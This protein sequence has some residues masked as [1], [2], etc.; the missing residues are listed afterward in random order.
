MGSGYTAMIL[1]LRHG[2]E[3]G[4]RMFHLHVE[5]TQCAHPSQENSH[6]SLNSPCL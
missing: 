6:A 1:Q 5:I 2:V 3:G 4:S